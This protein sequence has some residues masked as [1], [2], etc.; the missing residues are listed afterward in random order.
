[1]A[2]VH[3][4]VIQGR[5]DFFQV[6]DWLIAKASDLHANDGPAMDALWVPLERQL[7]AMKRWTDGGRQPTKDERKSIT[8]GRILSR[9]FEIA[10]TPDIQ[11][12]VDRFHELI[13]YFKHWKSDDDWQAID[14][15]DW[16]RNFPDEYAP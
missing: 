9:E 5:S 1:M 4:K 10:G 8:A 11:D 13:Y 7:S 2:R 6:L 12:F 14:D 3:H 15:T 16:T